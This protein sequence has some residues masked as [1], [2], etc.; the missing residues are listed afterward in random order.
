MTTMQTTQQQQQQREEGGD[1]HHHHHHHHRNQYQKQF[2]TGHSDQ[3]HDCQYDYYGR[4]RVVCVER[5][6][7]IIENREIDSIRRLF[8]DDDD[9]FFLSF[10]RANEK[11]QLCKE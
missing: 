9:L 11:Q 6:I 10:S 5:R 8:I 3:I 1:N 4:V 2:E 7:I